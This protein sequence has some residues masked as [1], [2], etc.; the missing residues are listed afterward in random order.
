MKRE[1]TLLSIVL[2]V[3][4]LLVLAGGCALFQKDE[5]PD[6]GK[7]DNSSEEA[8]GDINGT[9]PGDDSTP[10]ETSPG[11][12][13]GKEGDN[14]EDGTVKIT[15]Y[16]GDR[17]AIEE[18]SPCKTG[19]VSPVVREFPHTTAVLRLALEEL[20]RGPLSGEDNLVRTL[21]ATVEILNVKVEKE[22]ALID[23]SSDLVT[24]SPG[25]TLGGTILI[26]SLVYTAT[27]FPAV[28]SVL[29]TVEGETY[30]DGHRIWEYPISREDFNFSG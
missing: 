16:F 12:D 3:I 14:G 17:K 13:E 18:D 24:D 5:S 22:V 11:N 6:P 15:L 28:N 7:A 2:A 27:E 8:G 29:V 23:F 10:G 19:Y 1:I 20:I 9:A 30:S 4:I 21:P 25:G 26:Q